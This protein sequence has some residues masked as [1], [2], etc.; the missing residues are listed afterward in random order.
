MTRQMAETSLQSFA[1]VKARGLTKR[2]TEVYEAIQATI[3]RNR[4]V[5]G[6]EGATLY[7]VAESIHV[8]VNTISGRFT[9]LKDQG[10]IKDSG[11]R[12]ANRRGE[13]CTVWESSK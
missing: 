4:V 7:E 2:E 8:D 5:Y 6:L 3:I 10:R 13:S 9:G 12:R 11:Q 1:G